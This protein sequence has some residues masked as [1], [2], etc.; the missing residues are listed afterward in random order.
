MVTTKSRRP[1]KPALSPELAAVPDLLLGVLVEDESWVQG[2]QFV[3]G[4]RLAALLRERNPEPTAAEL[5]AWQ[6]L[7]DACAGPIELFDLG[8]FARVPRSGPIG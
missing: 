1:A 8:D 3:A 5:P 2:N 6:A 7:L 4:E